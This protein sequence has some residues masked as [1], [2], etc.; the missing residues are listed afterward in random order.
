MD[1]WILVAVQLQERLRQRQ[2]YVLKS[3]GM[4][5]SDEV[6]NFRFASKGIEIEPTQVKSAAPERTAKSLP[7][8]ASA[9][10]HTRA[11]ARRGK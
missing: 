3:R 5:H 6:R 2:L 7:R 10:T 1:S 4:P 11:I 8:R 9:A